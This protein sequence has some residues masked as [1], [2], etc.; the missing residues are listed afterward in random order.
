MLASLIKMLPEIRVL[1]ARPE[2]WRRQPIHEEEFVFDR[3]WYEL[4]NPWRRIMLHVMPANTETALFWHPHAVPCAFL[5]LG[6]GPYEVSFSQDADPRAGRVLTRGIFGY[7]MTH[8][9]SWHAVR[10][11][12]PSIS[13]GLLCAANLDPP[14]TPIQELLPTEE[15]A[16]VL[17]ALIA[18][19]VAKAR[20]V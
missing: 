20:H 13:I 18:D 16:R 2:D 5:I 11:Y 1:T 14:D 8:P 6:P 4:P 9:G 7:E 3:A 15:E 10:T 12:G 19:C 17:R